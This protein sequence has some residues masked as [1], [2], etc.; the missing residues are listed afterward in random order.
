MKKFVL[1]TA[2]LVSTLSL[3]AACTTQGTQTK[4]DL[5]TLEKD[6]NQLDTQSQQDVIG[7]DTVVQASPSPTTQNSDEVDSL[8]KEARSMKLDNESFQ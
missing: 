4:D 2:L 7:D 3:F 5:T 1:T 6:A 8:D